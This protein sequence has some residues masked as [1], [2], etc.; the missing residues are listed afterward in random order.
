ME[1]RPVMRARLRI[2]VIPLVMLVAAIAH[3]ARVE[4][5][6]ENPWIGAGFGMF[7]EI[8]GPQRSV[9]IEDSFGEISRIPASSST[10]LNRAA[11]YPTPP[12]LK[13][14]RE[15]LQAE[16]YDVERITV[17]RPVFTGEGSLRWAE[18]ARYGL[19]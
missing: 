18:V 5:H 17:L 13:K 9:E 14:L 19:D 7:A 11:N 8:D 1:E 15:V 12:A 3:G 16:G 6:G 2:V 4:Q 10:E